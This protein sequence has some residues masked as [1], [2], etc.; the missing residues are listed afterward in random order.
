M[1]AKFLKNADD[2]HEYQIRTFDD[3]ILYR[4]ELV[5]NS[6]NVADFVSLRG[7]CSIDRIHPIWHDKK[8]IQSIFNI[9][10]YIEDAPQYILDIIK[11][12]FEANNQMTVVEFIANHN[13]NF[14]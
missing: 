3:G 14:Y 11:E 10:D 8:V 9:G 5:H 7:K 1:K 6:G 4:L 13:N 12:Q 2:S